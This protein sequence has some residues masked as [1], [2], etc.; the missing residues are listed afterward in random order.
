MPDGSQIGR[1]TS[2]TL[3]TLPNVITFARLCAVPLSVWLVV[4][5]RFA[6]SFFLFV[7]AGLSDAVDGW[8]ARRNGGGNTVGALL[9]P[10]ADKALLVTMYVAL[11]VVKVVPDWLA[12]LVVFRDVVIVGGVVVLSLLGHPVLIR[13]LY[14]SKLNTALQIV[15][16][17]ASLLLSGF[18]LSAPNLMAVLVWLVAATTLGSG[19]AYVW[20]TVRHR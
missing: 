12:I 16:I 1:S 8:L 2:T 19:A 6:T 10:V 18:S 15:L 3:L 14:V 20:V 7:A 5:H 11:A 17:A 13:P 9:D 4:E